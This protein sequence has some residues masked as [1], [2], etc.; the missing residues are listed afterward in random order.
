MRLLLLALALHALPAQADLYRWI[1]RDTGS[2]K[3][4]SSP[5]PWY[6]DEERERGAPAVEVIRYRGAAARPA[7]APASAAQASAVAGLEARWSNLVQFFATLPPGTDF[8]RAGPGIQQQLEQ[9][10]AL[11]A[12]LDRLD[13]GGA[14]RRR[15]YEASAFEAIRRGLEAQFGV[16]PP[17]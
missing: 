6:G 9:Y 13:P 17:R 2:V 1:D 10:Q 15:S 14:A 16:R 5:P 3:Y 7:P 8:A 11:S 12:E 4:S